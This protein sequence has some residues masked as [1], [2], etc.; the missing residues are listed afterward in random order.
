MTNVRPP[1][2][3]VEDDA[4][5]QHAALSI[6]PSGI[7]GFVGFCERGPLDVPVRLSGMEAFTQI[8]GHLNRD[9]YLETSLNAF[10]DNGGQQCFV[11][12][13]AH[14]QESGPGVAA[15]A[16]K[17][18]VR[19]SKTGRRLVIEAASPGRWGDSLRF[20]V[21][22]HEGRLSTFLTLDADDGAEVLTLKSISGL[23]RG[24]IIRIFDDDHECYRYVRVTAGKEVALDEPVDRAW[25]SGAPTRVESIEFDLYVRGPERQEVFR[26]LTTARFGEQYVERVIDARSRLVRVVALNHELSI[27]DGIPEDL[28]WTALGD[29][30][31]GLEA[32]SP[33]D[34]IGSNPGIGERTGLK[35]LEEA[36]E[37]D[38]IVIPDLMW[39]LENS[40]NFKTLKDVEIVQQEMLAHA[41]SMRDRF[42]LLDVPPQSSP[43][44]AVQWRKMFDSAFGAFYY[45]WLA[46][47]DGDTERRLPPSGF[48]AG[49]FARVD[50]TRGVFHPPANEMIEGAVDLERILHDRDLGELNREGVNCLKSF[51]SRGVRIWGA[52]TASSDSSLR[53]VNVRRE[54][55]AIIK[56]LSSDLQWVVFE[57]NNPSLRKRVTMDVQF[58]LYDLWK[59]GYFRGGSPEDAFFV[60]CDAENNPPSARDA[61]QVVVDIGV[62]P[63]RPAEFVRFSITQT[64]D[65]SA[66]GVA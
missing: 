31:D 60:K 45:P 27:Q 29:G 53:Y 26:N 66:P 58:F 20:R 4:R 52:R 44:G 3:H 15:R 10:F 16:S 21:A 6:H 5:H 18:D 8:F 47:Y 65:E 22:R 61:G 57:P 62:S 48:V 14:R 56:T 42:A 34:F 17:A 55:N 28:D 46:T 11:V 12:R 19:D 39:C 23:A 33:A 59:A 40:E 63:V 50:N 54:L 41:E 25:M 30:E 36:E 2:V 49:V 64:R 51:P 38:L 13:I 7:P 37:I 9:T 1:G 43:G 24:T 35:A 32:L